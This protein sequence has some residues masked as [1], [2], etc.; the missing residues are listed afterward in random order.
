M[1]WDS[2]SDVFSLALRIGSMSERAGTRRPIMG[3]QIR[4]PVAVDLGCFSAHARYARRG[5]GWWEI[6]GQYGGRTGGD[7]RALDT[8]PSRARRVHPGRIRFGDRL[9]ALPRIAITD[10]SMWVNLMLINA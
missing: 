1:T 10:A 9:M 7:R 3:L 5:P 2:L 8:S 4:N 6:T